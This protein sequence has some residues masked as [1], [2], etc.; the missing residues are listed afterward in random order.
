MPYRHLVPELAHAS[1]P[2]DADYDASAV[3]NRNPAPRPLTQQERLLP[4][5]NIAHIMADVLPEKAKISKAAKELMQELTTEFI[6]FSTSESSDVSRSHNHKSI[7]VGDMVEGFQNVDLG[8]FVP[9]M[10]MHRRKQELKT[11]KKEH[12]EAA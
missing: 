3:A 10:L 8:M 7:G 2:D 4:L 12:G 6:C 9:L 5:A 11:A 1:E